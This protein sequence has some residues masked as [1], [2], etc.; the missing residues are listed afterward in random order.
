MDREVYLDNAATS[1]PKPESV[2]QAV[3]QF[4]RR[5]GGSPGRGLYAKAIAAEEVVYEARR[6]VADLFGIAEPSRIAFTANATEALNL[7][8]KGYL[9]QGDHVITTILEHNAVLRPLHTLE[10]TRGVRV[11][12][13]GA[14]ERGTLDIEALKKAFRPETRLVACVHGNNVLG[15][16]LP[17]AEVVRIAHDA[18]TAVLVDGSQTGGTLPVNLEELGVDM[19]AFTGHKGLLGPT[20]TGGLYLGPEIEL[21]TL[22]EGGTGSLSESLEAPD[23]LPDRFE[24]GTPNTVGLAGL[25]AGVR[26]LLERGVDSVREHEMK[27]SQRLFE[28]LKGRRGVTVYSPEDPKTRLGIVSMS[29]DDLNPTEAC[30]ILGN[31]FGVMVRCGLQCAPLTHRRLGTERQGVIRFSVGALSTEEDVDL[32]LTAVGRILEILYQGRGG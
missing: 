26:Y 27:L 4:M 19:F 10:R 21:E 2:Y 6:E 30:G 29:F 15:T 22:K 7:A 24:P 31:K 14:D 3:D 20:G 13:V 18:G 28:G 12:Y 9:Q 25:G 11:T 1:F 17:L 32:A 8:L 23:F 5:C 16:I